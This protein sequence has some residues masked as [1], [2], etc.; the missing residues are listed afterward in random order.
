ML[1]AFEDD[2]AL[3]RGGL[4]NIITWAQATDWMMMITQIT[5]VTLTVDTPSQ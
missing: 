5:M 4:G 2:V 3:G 1:A